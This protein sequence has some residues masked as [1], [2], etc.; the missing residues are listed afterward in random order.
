[1]EGGRNA[2]LQPRTQASHRSPQGT[3]V[4]LYL[5][6]LTTHATHLDVRQDGLL[7]QGLHIG[8][9]H[10]LPSEVLQAGLARQPLRK[11]VKL[12]AHWPLQ[13][14]EGWQGLGG[15]VR[16]QGREGPALLTHTIHTHAHTRV[17]THQWVITTQLLLHLLAAHGKCRGQV[18]HTKKANNCCHPLKCSLYFYQR[19]QT[20]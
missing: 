13:R 18:T 14:T 2:L 1:M 15:G 20:W 5:S 9:R 11:P 17:H 6:E 19:T 3:Q 16:E 12:Q 10:V 4:T 8:P 7:L